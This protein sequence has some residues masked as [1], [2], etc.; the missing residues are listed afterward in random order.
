MNPHLL[1][2]AGP[3][4]G[5]TFEL[6]DGELTLGRE[7]SNSLCLKDPRVSRRHA[8]I[9]SRGQPYTLVDLDSSNGTFVNGLPVT[10]HSLE[11]GDQIEIGGT[12]LLF[13]L[14]EEEEPPNPLLMDSD[15]KTIVGRAAVQLHPEDCVYLTPTPERV[16]AVVPDR[17]AGDLKALLHICTEINS[18]RTLDSLQEKLLETTF[19]AVPGDAAAILLFDDNAETPSS[20]FTSWRNQRQGQSVE[21]SRNLVRKVIN[22]RVGLLNH[23][24][25][26]SDAAA[27]PQTLIRRKVES[28]LCAPLFAL[29]RIIG[30]IYIESTA[31][32]FRFDERHLQFVLAIAGIAALPLDNVR[33]LEWLQTENRRL[34]SDFNLDHA[35]VGESARMKEIY[36]FIGKVAQSDSTVLIR[37]ESGT[38]KEL[39]ARAVHSNSSRSDRP[40]VAINC[41]ALTETLLESELFGHEKGAFT[42]A[43]TQKR[44]K[45]EVAD[46]GT[47]FLDEVGELAPGIQAKLLRALQERQFERVGGTRPIK[48]NIRLVAATNRELERAIGEGTFRQDLYYRL[49]VVSVTI[50]SLKE[51]REDIPLIARY[52][53]A[54]ASKRCGRMV[55]ALSPEV[56]QCLMNYDWP[57]NVRELENAIERAVVLGT[58]EMIVAE[59]LPETILEKSPLRDFQGT[60]Y[61][62]GVRDAKRQLI[63]NAINQARGNYTQAAKLLGLHPNNL[64][65]LI[66]DLDLKSSLKKEH[67]EEE[68]EV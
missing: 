53:A 65:R 40:F 12:L 38:G 21:V 59:D 35:M 50:P 6:S 44:G 46:G 49:N 26:A 54:Q 39:V 57:G 27:Q 66:R 61:H 34:K 52:F 18:A 10:Q 64:H 14:H 30:V 67:Q 15:P 33:Q 48:V 20:T 7:D 16:P 32:G 11:H 42:G 62:R 19:K 31:L 1:V 25:A 28:V 58:T 56:R 13:A 43:M 2:L 68:E 23:P 22:D 8:I 4:K 5:Q 3:L 29:D 41:A 24:S 45:F 63:L 9:E 37:G 60:E 17:M 51:R 47:L 36:R 55:K